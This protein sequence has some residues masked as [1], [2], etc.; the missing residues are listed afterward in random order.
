MGL[1]RSAPVD[2]YVYGIWYERPD[3]AN[4]FWRFLIYYDSGYFLLGK[5]DIRFVGGKKHILMK[6]LRS[7]SLSLP[8]KWATKG[9]P[10]IRIDF[11]NEYNMWDVA[12]FMKS[13]VTIFGA[14]SGTFGLYNKLIW[15]YR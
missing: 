1:R 3:R 6:N 2:E 14:N 12:F 15:E 5:N 13:A 8:E 7:I 10:Y 9:V 11:E 4:K